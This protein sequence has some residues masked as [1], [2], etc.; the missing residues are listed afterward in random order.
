MNF[1]SFTF[2]YPVERSSLGPTLPSSTWTGTSEG[3]SR[4]SLDYDYMRKFA[5][6]E[7]QLQDITNQWTLSIP[8]H[9]SIGV[10]TADILGVAPSTPSYDDDLQEDLPRKKRAK[11]KAIAANEN[12]E[13][14]FEPIR[15]PPAVAPP[16]PTPAQRP[17][18]PVKAC[19][20][21]PR[22]ASSKPT[23]VKTFAI[24]LGE[25][26]VEDPHNVRC[27]WDGCH[28]VIPR[29]LW[30]GHMNEYVHHLTRQG[31]KNGGWWKCKWPG[32][33]IRENTHALME[34]HLRKSH[35][36]KDLPFCDMCDEFFDGRD[37]LKEHQAEEHADV[38]AYR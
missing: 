36:V 12:T 38:L 16:A 22:A 17:P 37:E 15:H 19:A 1:G 3:P 20:K 14:S 2:E 18:S 34:A 8:W 23:T 29:V 13:A 10:K 21:R 27:H 33:E 26:D 11:G 31:V 28:Q 6:H 25:L 5:D 30:Q 4:T 7:R 35:F 9:G 24:H 32:C